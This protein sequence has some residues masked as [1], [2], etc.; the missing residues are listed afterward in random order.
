MIVGYFDE[1]PPGLPPKVKNG[2]FLA[3]TYSLAE[4]TTKAKTMA[5]LSCSQSRFTF[6]NVWAGSNPSS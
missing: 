2:M 4:S 5:T 1:N 3:L 6:D